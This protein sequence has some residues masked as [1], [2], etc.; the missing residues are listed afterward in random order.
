M[1]N[2][3]N[4]S[5]GLLCSRRR[6][7]KREHDDASGD[8]DGSFNCDPGPILSWP[9]LPAQI[10]VHNNMGWAGNQY[11]CRP[12]FISSRLPNIPLFE[13]SRSQI[14]QFICVFSPKLQLAGYLVEI[15]IPRYLGLVCKISRYLSSASSPAQRLALCDQ[16]LQ[17]G[18]FGNLELMKTGLEWTGSSRS[19]K[20]PSDRY[21]VSCVSS[22]LCSA[23][24]RRPACGEV[25]WAAP[26]V[27]MYS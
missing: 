11:T 10:S 5:F 15:I 3:S 4:P 19:R 23:Y 25:H 20:A 24:V 12:A 18:I 13:L 21:E 7:K 27:N 6:G 1:Y 26:Y 8:S 17:S 2:P 14:I 16:T 9:T 22:F